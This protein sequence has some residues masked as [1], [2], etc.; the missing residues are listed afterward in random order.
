MVLE[1]GFYGKFMGIVN[2]L[3]V[4]QDLLNNLNL[5]KQPFSKPLYIKRS[6]RLL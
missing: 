1:V 3:P 6:E 5:E 4:A 2:I